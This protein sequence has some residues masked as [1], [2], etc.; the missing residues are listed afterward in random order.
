[1]RTIV[2]V[3][4]PKDWN[5]KTGGVEIV[6]AKNYLTDLSYSENKSM[7]VFN[8][9]RS[10]RYQATGY[11]VSLLAEARGH[12][13]FPNVST[14]QDLK[15]QTIIRVISDD[16]DDL[17]Q[18]SLKKIKSDHFTLSI[19]FGR[20]IAVQ[21]DRL[22]SQL[23]N[24]F[25]APLIRAQFVFNKKWILQSISPVPVNEIPETHWQYVEDFAGQYFSKKRIHSARI[26]NSMYDMAILV[27]ENETEP[28]SNHKAIKHF[29][30]AGEEIGIRCETITKDDFSRIP[31]YDALFIRETTAV[32]H[33]T[34]RFSRRAFTEGLVVIDDPR[35]IL[36][37]TN[38]VY[39]AEILSKAKIHAPKTIIVNKEN[40]DILE[41]ELGFPIVLKQPDSSFSQGVIKVNNPNELKDNVENLLNDSDLIIAQE[42]R[43]SEFDWRIGIIDKEPL[44]A[45]K[46]YMAK[47]HWQIYNWKGSKN[48]KYGNFESV[49]IYNVP[50]NILKQ[51]LKAANLIGDG[52][53]GVDLKQ[54]GSEVFV[55]EVNDNPSIESG[56]EDQIMKDHLYHTIMK[57]F[58]ERIEKLR[59]SKEI[60]L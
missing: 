11:Y 43:Y 22:A 31:E 35:S 47:D 37:C 10:Y 59:F 58:K 29:I 33:H 45:C 9:C 53:Y 27:N 49:P 56:V 1:M 21:Y 52:L 46:Y 23:Y 55:I 7:R 48:D 57:S 14:I 39:L 38:K 2:V 28:P 54:I 34:Y 25:Q 44:F 41:K 13:V 18:T 19:Y 3:N 36:K 16:L 32:N 60:S 5:F 50:K 6:S 26:S 30:E 51:A 24:L 15:S 40:K 20:N 4:N 8:L 42:F 12:K 17:I